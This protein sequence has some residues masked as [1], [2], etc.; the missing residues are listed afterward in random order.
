V[1]SANAS[2]PGRSAGA[3]PAGAKAERTAP[4]G[5]GDH[6]HAS[7]LRDVE[8][9]GIA[10]HRSR[11]PPVPCVIVFGGNDQEPLTLELDVDAEDVAKSLRGHSLQRIEAKG[12]VI[13]VNPQNVLYVEDASIPSTAE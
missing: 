9:S 3:S 13:W 1:C 10:A 2:S 4:C 11:L 6:R 5:V 12:R 7:N 8:R